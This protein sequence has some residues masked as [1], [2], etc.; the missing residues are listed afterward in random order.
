MRHPALR[1]LPLSFV[2]VACSVGPSFERPAAKL[3]DRWHD[4]NAIAKEQSAVPKMEGR[5]FA[6]EW[7][8]QFGDERLNQLVEHTR[9]NNL[10]LR[11]A[12]LRMIGS[13]VQRAIATGER[14]PSI[15]A[16]GI[17]QRHRESEFGVNTRL[18][19]IIV[20]PGATRD[21][22]VTALS[23]PFD[24]YQ[25]GFDASWEID[26]WGRVRRAVEAADANFAASREDLHDAELTVV[27]EVVRTYLELIGA[28][29]QLRIAGDDVAARTDQ[30]ELTRFR[31]ESGFVTSLDLSVQQAQLSNVRAQ[32]P[33]LERQESM[34][35]NALAF[36]VGGDPHSLNE[37]LDAS[38]S[39]PTVPAVVATGVPSELARRRPDIRRAEARLHAAT[40]EIGVA[41]ADLYPRISLTGS[42]AQQSLN[43]SDLAEWGA[44]QWVIG[45][46]ISLPIFQGGRLRSVVELRKIQQQ[47]AA[48]NYQRT[49]L[50][51]WHEIDN[52]LETYATEL[53]RNRELADVVHASQD[54]YDVAHVRYQHG[55]VDSFIDL[56][57]HRTLLQAQR[58]YSESNTQIGVQLVALCK[59]LGGGWSAAE[60]DEAV[61]TSSE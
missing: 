3:P 8:R 43:A 53:R 39:L 30:L 28:R 22:I 20:P 36:M 24:V 37:M 49:V 38:R 9:A 41:V 6:G 40:A 12:T 42:F 7:W 18:I 2:L 5:T 1:L 33:L 13:R 56:D 11:L 27:A 4:E 47:E 23:E 32:I 44:R 29:D 45:P 46:S 59:A 19:D 54:A 26:L 58:A 48:V 14:W 52:A 25:V 60:S 15:S 55:L 34:L 50:S 16:S 51:A 61:R 10:D 31:T 21:Q 17:Y 57:A 35:Q